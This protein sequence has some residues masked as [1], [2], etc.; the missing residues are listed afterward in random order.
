MT[1]IDWDVT[2]LNSTITVSI[3]N[4][5]ALE[6]SNMLEV[7]V[8]L[9]KSCQQTLSDRIAEMERINNRISLV[10]GRLRSIKLYRFSY[11]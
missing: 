3:I 5:V 11:N 6:V 7:Y 4:V 2:V 1:C 10:K 9:Q 8:I